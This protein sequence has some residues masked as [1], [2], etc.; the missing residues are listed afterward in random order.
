MTVPY[1]RIQAVLRTLEL[2]KELAAGALIDADTLRRRA[3][4]LL[5][6]YP[7]PVDLDLSAAALPGI[8]AALRVKWYE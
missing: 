4:A 1:E 2:L 3:A 6:H 7:A 8:W 5:K